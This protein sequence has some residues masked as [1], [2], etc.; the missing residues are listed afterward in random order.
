[1]SEPTLHLNAHET[2]RVVRET[3]GE[4]ELEAS[5]SPGGSR[6]PAHLHPAQDEQFE[7]LAGSL[8][9][10]VHGRQRA[11]TAGERLEI[12]R[13]TP[14]TLWNSGGEE[15]RVS[16]RTRPAGRTAE[17]FRAVD[18]LTG[19]GTRNPPLPEMAA[20][21]VRYRDAFQLAVG[22]RPLWPLEGAALRLLALAARRS[23]ER[24]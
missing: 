22:P 9:A 17:W 16:W 10:L 23:D 4:L 12:P 13:G 3:P 1:V 18:G 11:L 5:W 24:A 20:V 21:L 8:T 15:A 6:P 7:V 19:A 14:H 2:V